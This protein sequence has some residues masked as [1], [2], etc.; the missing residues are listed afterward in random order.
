MTCRL[1][2]VHTYTPRGACGQT[3]L[4][5]SYL[6]ACIAVCIMLGVII[7]FYKL[8]IFG[9]VAPAAFDLSPKEHVPLWFFVLVLVGSFAAFGLLLTS[10]LRAV[11]TSPG[12]VDPALWRSKPV[13]VDE[14]PATHSEPAVSRVTR[15]GDLRYCSRCALYKPDD[16]HHC[17]DCGRCV[18]KMDHH[19]PW[20]NNCVGR[21]NEK[22]FL[23]FI[24]YVPV[25][26]AYIIASIGM[27]YSIS[28]TAPGFR[29]NHVGNFIIALAAGTFGLVLGFFGLFHAHLIATSQTT[30]DHKFSTERQRHWSIR[31]LT[32]NLPP[33]RVIMERFALV[34]GPDWRWWWLPVSPRL[35][36]A[37]GKLTTV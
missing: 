19:C 6:P 30:L 7:P 3:H 9:T 37:A 26:A 17:S 32:C 33:A 11:F 4:V 14:A 8:F 10:Y 23:L 18:A 16:A 29:R 1:V 24:V 2:N 21:D 13:V 31:I 20:I 36:H 28:G 25:S 35:D 12:F 5:C 22:F 34:L 27:Y 15:A